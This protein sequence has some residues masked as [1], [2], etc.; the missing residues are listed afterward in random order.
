M[1]TMLAL[2]FRW[3]NH[4]KPA[5]TVDDL[6]SAVSK[7]EI[8]QREYTNEDKQKLVLGRFY[9]KNTKL[10]VFAEDH[11]TIDMKLF[12]LFDTGDYA[13]R[14]RK[15]SELP[16][17]PTVYIG[18]TGAGKTFQIL[19]HAANGFVCYTTAAD[20]PNESDKYYM[21]LINAFTLLTH[22]ENLDVKADIATSMMLLWII[23][24]LACLYSQLINDENFTPLQFAASQIGTASEYYA[25]CFYSCLM[26]NASTNFFQLETI[27]T[28]LVQMI[29]TK[30]KYP[31]GIAFDEAQIMLKQYNQ[32]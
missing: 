10:P 3:E 7:H 29:R 24:K 16:S 6:L 19:K 20:L 4:Q 14:W 18:V 13:S 21:R 1:S 8:Q 31:I 5:L 9:R 11:D 26:I 15:S 17:R 32:G 22:I 30:T 25:D 2:Q 28:Q 12:G 23:T 27:H